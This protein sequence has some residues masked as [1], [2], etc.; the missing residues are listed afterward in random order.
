MLYIQTATNFLDKKPAASYSFYENI[1]ANSGT[2]TIV[3]IVVYSVAVIFS[4]QREIS[5]Y[6][7]IRD[8]ITADVGLDGDILPEHPSFMLLVSFWIVKTIIFIP[9]LFTFGNL[10]L[11]TLR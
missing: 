9:I 1:I 5:D 10:A 2:F 3:V 4:N 8:S 11:A 6:K 7:E